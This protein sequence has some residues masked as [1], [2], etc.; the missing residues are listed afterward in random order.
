M[1]HWLTSTRCVRTGT[2]ADRVVVEESLSHQPSHVRERCKVRSVPATP[3]ELCQ[4]HFQ[5]IRVMC[6][7]FYAPTMPA[8]EPGVATR[9]ST[10]KLFGVPC[11]LK[12]AAGSCGREG[13]PDKA[14]RSPPSHPTGFHAALAGDRP[15][16]TLEPARL[17]SVFCISTPSSAS[18]GTGACGA[19]SG[20]L[21]CLVAHSWF[22]RSESEQKL[23]GCACAFCGPFSGFPQE[24]TP[25]PHRIK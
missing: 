15:T 16:H 9:E 8:E 19:C 2:Q 12:L 23:D 13:L 17:A 4:S 1:A 6:A 18:A 21:T 25:G 22:R 3:A 5:E 11:R 24:S 10:E 14:C 7:C 20:W